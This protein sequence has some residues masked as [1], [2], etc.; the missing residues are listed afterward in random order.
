MEG[1]HV[2]FFSFSGGTYVCVFFSLY[3]SYVTGY[4]HIFFL[5]NS[6]RVFFSSLLRWHEK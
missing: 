5:S 4:V 3:F 2:M 1:V 6:V